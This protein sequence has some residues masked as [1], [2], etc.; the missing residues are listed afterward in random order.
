MSYNKNNKISLVGKAMEC[1]I[2]LVFRFFTFFYQFSD[3][4]IRILKT[5]T[6]LARI[7]LEK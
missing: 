6:L 7:F 3:V 4:T 1:F 5:K 2:Q